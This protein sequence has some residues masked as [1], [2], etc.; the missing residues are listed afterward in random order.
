MEGNIKQSPFISFDNEL[1]YSSTFIPQKH[2]INEQITSEEE[3]GPVPDTMSKNNL[4]GITS[5]IRPKWKIHSLTSFS[6]EYS[7]SSFL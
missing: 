6:L 7:K 2:P 5:V 3:L 4:R 1:D